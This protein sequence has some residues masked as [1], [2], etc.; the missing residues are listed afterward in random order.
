MADER[1]RSLER[2]TAR[3]DDLPSI[4]SS[5]S[6]IM[7]VL[8][9]PESST[10]EL[11]EAIGTDQS[12]A[13]RLLKIVN[14]A[15]YG[16]P[17]K[18]DSLDQAV[19]VLGYRSIRELL[20][21][22]TL[23]NEVNSRTGQRSLDRKR[24]WEHAL[25]CGAAAKTIARWKGV[26]GADTI[27]LAGLL[28]DIGKVF[29]DAFLHDEYSQIVEAAQKK[30]LLLIEAEEYFL[31]VNHTDFGHWLAAEWNLPANLTAAILYHHEPDLAKN[32]YQVACLVHIGDVLVRALEVGYGGD[33]LIPAI[34]RRAWASLN[35]TMPSLEN[36][37]SD[38]EENLAG[39]P[40]TL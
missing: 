17:R 2:L 26:S 23:L 6:R 28:H 14:S 7:A 25:G 31:G 18:I 15:Y 19:T 22:T 36:L 39:F 10:R 37:I 35:L 3:M 4:P 5:V 32:H 20:L 1:G 34:N 24:F 12:L 30:N 29:L 27:F 33:E 38:F 9:D 13:T 11:T 8:D 16:F 21:V 40:L